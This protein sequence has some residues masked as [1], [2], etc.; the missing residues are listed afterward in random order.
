MV[1]YRIVK[2]K[3]RAADLSGIGSYHNGGRWNSPGTYVVY[4]SE[5]RALAAFELLVH[6]DISEAPPGMFIMSVEIVD[7]AP[8]YEVPD[9]LLPP[10]W[11]GPENAALKTLGDRLLAENKYIAL[12]VRSA[13]MPY[14]YNYILNPRFPPF[15][16]MVKVIEVQEYN[17]DQRLL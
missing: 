17:F 12:K 3:I 1:V 15:S 2:Q 5:S 7:G 6:L 13:V 4:T 11:P 10:K 8:V 9:E 14:E 16:D